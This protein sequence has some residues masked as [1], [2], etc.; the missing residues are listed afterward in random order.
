MVAGQSGLLDTAR[1]IIVI[2]GAAQVISSEMFL[3]ALQITTAA[4]TTTILHSV[5]VAE[6]QA[7]AQAA[8]VLQEV[9]EALH[10]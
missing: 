10:L 8:P 5:Q 1:V 3:I 9:A 4:V 7:V 2:Q 6:V